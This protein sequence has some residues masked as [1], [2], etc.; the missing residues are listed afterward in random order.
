VLKEV[1][2]RSVTLLRHGGKVYCVDSLC[3]HMGG[4]LGQTGDIEDM[5]DGSACIK[6][7]WHNFRFDLTSGCRLEKGL[8][9]GEVLRSEPQQRVHPVYNDGDY[10]WVHLKVHGSMAS[11]AYNDCE[12]SGTPA[13]LPGKQHV[14]PQQQGFGLGMDEFEDLPSSQES[15]AT[16]AGSPPQPLMPY[17]GIDR[18]PLPPSPVRMAPLRQ[19]PTAQISFPGRKAS[20]AALRRAKATQAVQSRTYMPPQVASDQPKRPRQATVTDLFGRHAAQQTVIDLD[21]MDES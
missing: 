6:C 13:G 11:D 10:I 16:A 21:D 4:P 9:P 20:A 12:A 7:P 2:G 19:A 1:L 5:Q 15:S 17:G 18:K 8:C 14:P 3:S